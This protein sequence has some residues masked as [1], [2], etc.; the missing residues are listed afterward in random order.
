MKDP[1][2]GSVRNGPSAAAIFQ[3]NH[4][5]MFVPSSLPLYGHRNVL[6]VAAGINGDDFIPMNEV[7]F[8]KAAE[9]PAVTP[10]HQVRTHAPQD[11][12]A[13]S[14]QRIAVFRSALTCMHVALFR[15]AGR[16]GAR[17]GRRWRCATRRRRTGSTSG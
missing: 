5:F 6:S 3:I 9:D 2:D 15:T 8:Y 7:F 13:A 14:W 12:N 1:A 17:I 4:P 16:I 11:A 10:W